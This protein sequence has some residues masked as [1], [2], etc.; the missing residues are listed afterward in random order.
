M[1]TELAAKKKR[2]VTRR[3]PGENASTSA[4]QLRDPGNGSGSG[5]RW[6]GTWVQGSSGQ[7]S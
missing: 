7:V 5:Q 4:G 2:L 1:H 3:G 6:Q